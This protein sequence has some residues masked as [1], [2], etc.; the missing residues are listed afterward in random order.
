[1]PDK[2]SVYPRIRL[3]LMLENLR[4]SPTIFLHKTSFSIFTITK[5]KSLKPW[6]HGGVAQ[7]GE[8]LL[9]KQGVRGSIPLISTSR[10]VAARCVRKGNP[11]RTA[12]KLRSVAQVVRARA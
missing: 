4:H 1:M 12:P 9:C 8:H 7:L 10:Q 6:K 11:E 3:R 2:P 5:D